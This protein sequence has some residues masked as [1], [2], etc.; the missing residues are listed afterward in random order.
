[1]AIIET[2]IASDL[3]AN[4][5]GFL[6]L[7]I[8]VVK[9]YLRKDKSLV[10]TIELVYLPDMTA[11]RGLNQIACLVDDAWFADSHQIAC[12]L[13][14]NLG[15]ELITCEPRYTTGPLYGEIAFVVTDAYTH[16]PTITTGDIALLYSCGIV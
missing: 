15:V 13:K 2:S 16:S 8:F 5:V 9:F 10:V 4:E 11:V 12:I 1:M 3:T 7:L 6:K 14:G